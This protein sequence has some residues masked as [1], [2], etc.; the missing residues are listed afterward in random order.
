LF[1]A[2]ASPMFC[3]TCVDETVVVGAL[4]I[5]RV[6]ISAGS[7]VSVAV[8]LP[9]DDSREGRVPTES[10]NGSGARFVA[11]DGRRFELEFAG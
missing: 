8:V 1:D 3:E 11:V 9:N 4:T 2:G 10:A 7:T 5:V 6:A